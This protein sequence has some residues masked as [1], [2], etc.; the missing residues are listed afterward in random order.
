[1]LKFLLKD[2]PSVLVFLP[3]LVFIYFLLNYQTDYFEV[4]ARLD[5]GLWGSFSLKK[6]ENYFIYLSTLLVLFN[7]IIRQKKLY[8]ILFLCGA[9]QFFPNDVYF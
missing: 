3:I 1:M 8:Y 7:A 4:K 5:F 2:N 6:I 9:T